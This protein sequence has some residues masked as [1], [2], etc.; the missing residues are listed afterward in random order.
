LSSQQLRALL[1][2]PSFNYPGAKG[3]ALSSSQSLGSF[4]KFFLTAQL[5]L[6]RNLRHAQFLGFFAVDSG[7]CHLA[8]ALKQSSLFLR[9]SWRRRL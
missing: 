8:K 6:Y 4:F 3:Q 7:A 5:A 2:P 1:K 9:A